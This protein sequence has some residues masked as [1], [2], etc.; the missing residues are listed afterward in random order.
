[1]IIKRHGLRCTELPCHVQRKWTATDGND[2]CARRTRQLRE[3]GAKETDADDRDIILSVNPATIEDIHRAAK[4]FTWKCCVVKRRGKFCYRG[5]F[6]DVVI[7][8]CAI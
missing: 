1:M 8:V 5:R 7:G 2:L 4:R 6:A 3:Q